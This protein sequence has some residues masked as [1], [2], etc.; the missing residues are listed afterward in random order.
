[1]K[2]QK[3]DLIRIKNINNLSLYYSVHKVTSVTEHPISKKTCYVFKLNEQETWIDEED[4]Q[5]LLGENSGQYVEN[6]AS[7][8]IIIDTVCAVIRSFGVNN[9]MLNYCLE[10]CMETTEYDPDYQ[11]IIS[12]YNSQNVIDKNKIVE[13]SSQYYNA[14]QLVE[15]TLVQEKTPSVFTNILNSIQTIKDQYTTITEIEEPEPVQD[16]NSQTE[17]ENQEVEVNQ[18]VPV[19][20]SDEDKEE[21]QEQISFLESILGDDLSNKDKVEEEINILRNKLNESYNDVIGMIVQPLI[22]LMDSIASLNDADKVYEL[23]YNPNNDQVVKDNIEG[24]YDG[25]KAVL[26]DK[27]LDEWKK[28]TPETSKTMLEDKNSLPEL[29]IQQL[30]DLFTLMKTYENKK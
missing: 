22:S 16:T 18:E 11:L 19:E 15:Q 1:M 8:R 30:V 27:V 6:L 28:L 3:G 21:I 25:F 26:N 12:D 17:I 2:A 7:L 29:S 5:V 13:L 20:L 24:L 10:V 4:T 23:N 9:E 14:L